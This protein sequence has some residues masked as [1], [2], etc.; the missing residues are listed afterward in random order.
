MRFPTTIISRKFDGSINRRWE[1]ELI[2]RSGQRLTFVGSFG[3][4]VEHPEL[5][6]IER[7]TI[8]YE[9]YWLDRWYNV[10]RFHRPDGTLRNW[11][12]NVN[13]PPRFKGDVLDYIDLDLDLLVW[14]DLST[15]ILD[16][17][18]FERNSECY[19]YPDAVREGAESALGELRL[20]IDGRRF[21]FEYNYG[22]ENTTDEKD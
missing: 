16:R 17:D 11:Y 8:S 14:P 13:L 19:D 15:V 1:A 3:M 7:G 21:P 4:D 5:G 22:S 6:F 18:D 10:F 20:M 12:C 2:G 9:H